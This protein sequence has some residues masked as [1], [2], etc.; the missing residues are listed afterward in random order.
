MG[1]HQLFLLLFLSAEINIGSTEDLPTATVVVVSPQPPL[2]PGDVVTLRCAIAYRTIY[3]EWHYYWYRNGYEDRSKNT[4]SI[5]IRLPEEEGQYECGGLRKNHPEISCRSAQTEIKYDAPPTATVVVVSPQSPFYFGERVTLRCNIA[6]YTDWGPYSWYRDNSPL[7]SQASETIT[8]TLPQE[9][10]QYQCF[11]QRKDR[12]Q[13]SS[14]SPSAE[15]TYDVLPTATVMVVS[16][17]RPFYSGE[18]VTLRCDIANYRD[19]GPYSWYRDNSPL[20]SQA[21]EFI[22]ITLPQEEGQYQCSGQ[23]NYSPHVSSQSEHH[24]IG[25]K[26]EKPTPTIST[27]SVAPVFTGNSVTLRCDMG[28]STG[29]RFFWYRHTQTSD[30]VAQTD[31]DSYS[32]S[33]VKVSDGGQYWCRAGRGN[34]VYYT[35]YS[36]EVWVKVTESPKAVVTLL[37]NWTDFF[38][39]ERI[40]FRCDIQGDQHGHWQY[41]WYKIGNVDIGTPNPLHTKQEYTIYYAKESHSGEYSCRGTRSSDPQTSE[42]SASV[43]IAITAKPKPVLRGPPQTW[44]TEGDSVTL[45][46]EVRGSTTGWRFHWYKTAPQRPEL[47]YITHE[48]GGYYVE[49]VSDSIRGAGGSYT[50]SPAALRHTGVYVCRAERGEPAIP[51]K[52][53]QPQPLWIT[54]NSHPSSLVVHPNTNQHFDWKYLSLSCVGSVYLTGWKLRWFSGWSEYKMCPNGWAEAGSTCRRD[55]VSSSDSGIYWCQSDSGEQSNPVNITVHT[56][57]VIL[58][59]PVH[60]VTEGDPLTLRCRYRHQPSNISADFYK[61]G[62]LLQTSTTGEMTIPAVSKSHEGLYKCSNPERAESPESWIT[63][64]GSVP[65]SGSSLLL[66]VGVVVGLVLMIVLIVILVLL[67]RFKKLKAGVIQTPPLGQQQ[68]N[69]SQNQDLSQSAGNEGDQLGYEPLHS[70]STNVYDSIGTDA[71]SA[72]LNDVTYATIDLQTSSDKVKKKRKKDGGKPEPDIVYSKLKAVKATGED[73]TEDNDLTYV[74]VTGK[75][76]GVTTKVKEFQVDAVYSEVKHPASSG[77]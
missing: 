42:I 2:Y 57:D 30:P 70:G 58:E 39:G 1:Q 21:S 28:Q 38:H 14:T 27:E 59:S 54:G 16:S 48:N 62:S 10:G 29:W 34:P 17:Q 3:T 61:D 77:V 7:P 33:S 76:K 11:G 15:I 68:L 66:T 23:R 73:D 52:F 64:N 4:E 60:P 24:L 53:S 72:G 55:R 6:N 20:P 49:G 71:A 63:V 51:T 32:I 46:C 45:S 41:S 75:K 13:I 47:T 37:S 8:I 12:P 65:H 19:W 40:N 67:Y 36:N 9:A 22:T 74:Q 5:S 25:C 44:L 35:Q 56:G 50:L 26:E 18:R 31:G 43:R 69:T